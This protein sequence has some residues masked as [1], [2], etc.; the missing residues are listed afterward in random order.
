MYAVFIAHSLSRSLFLVMYARSTCQ[1]SNAC[2]LLH[3]FYTQ[4]PCWRLPLF[5]LFCKGV[6]ENGSR[7]V[8]DDV[9][10]VFFFP[11]ELAPRADCAVLIRG[12]SDNGTRYQWFSIFFIFCQFI[13]KTGWCG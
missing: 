1:D 9:K 10:P 3:T 11:A 5:L 13:S 6:S 4:Y 8:A 7:I 12:M 2:L